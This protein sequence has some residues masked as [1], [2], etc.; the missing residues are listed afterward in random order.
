MA[1][2]DTAATR[3]VRTRP[4]ASSRHNGHAPAAPAAAILVVV[5]TRPEVIKLAPVVRAL[6]SDARFVIRLCVVAQQGELLDQALHEWGLRAD[7]HVAVPGP[8][9][10]LASSLAQMLPGLADVIAE[11]QP[12]MVI[13]EG[14]TTTN[15]AAALAAFY[16]GVPVAHVEAGLRSGDPQQPFPEEMHRIL[17]DRIASVHYAPTI[18]A[19]Q[20][21]LAEN[22]LEGDRAMVVGNTVVDALLSA[23]RD[24]AIL[25]TALPAD[26]RV[27]LATAHRRENFGNGIESI[28]RAV[29][30]LAT[31]RD[32]LDVVFVLHSNPAAFGPVRAALGGLA[33]VHLIEPQPYRAFVK[34][35]ARADIVL[36][37]S[38]GVQEEA[39]YLG[40][41][42]LVTR[43]LTERPEASEAG[44]A[45]I[46]GTDS[47]AIVDAVNRLLDDEQL[48]ARM[49]RHISPYGD[50][51][52][53]ERIRADLSRR[54]AHN[55]ARQPM[56]PA[57]PVG[58]MQLLPVMSQAKLAS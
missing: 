27:L 10:R 3:T 39:P 18:G 12:E 54:L 17:V 16:A 7:Y 30:R 11:A 14:D 58:D 15:L 42:V 9:R 49:A 1:L 19:R 48:Y 24:P 13:V 44:A 46:V 45:W 57:D 53:A 2:R 29:Q 8:D 31:E 23:A 4:A 6:E 20:N 21:L 41:P 43:E 32:D 5:G 52:A 26:R 37:D 38:G 56:R 25:T 35:L 36:T 40:T 47:N 51:R 33:N 28:C 34:L 50:G 55:E 22:L